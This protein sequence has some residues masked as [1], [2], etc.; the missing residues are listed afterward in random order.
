LFGRNPTGYG[1]GRPQYPDAVYDVLTDRCGLGRHCAALEVG[2]GTGL[3]TQ[4]LLDAGASVVAIEP[5][6]RMADHLRVHVHGE[7]QVIESTLEEAPIGEGS[8]DLAVAATALHWVDQEVGLRKLG[9]AV[10][11]GGWVALWWLF[12]DPENPDEFH[13]SA[14]Q[15]VGRTAGGAFNEAGRPPFQLDREHR[16]R[17]MR[18]WAGLVDLV[19][20]YFPFTFVMTPHQARLLYSSTAAVLRHPEPEQGRLLDAIERLARDEFGGR[21]ERRFLAAMYTGRRPNE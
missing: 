8:F 19:G 5:D 17:D 2:P 15:I 11:P 10:H 9:R 20:E 12:G 1:T 16:L 18:T 3:V 4:R 6:A 21:V 7:L 14:E 13:R